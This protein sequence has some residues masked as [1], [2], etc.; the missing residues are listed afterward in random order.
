MSLG[1]NQNRSQP[2]VDGVVYLLLQRSTDVKNRI[3]MIVTIFNQ[4]QRID[5]SIFI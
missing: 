5:I 2:Q 4:Q 1:E 3:D